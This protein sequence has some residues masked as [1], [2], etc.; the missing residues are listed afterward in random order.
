[1]GDAIVL[2]VFLGVVLVFWAFCCWAFYVGVLRP[3]MD[4]KWPMPR[5]GES[6]QDW[7]RRTGIRP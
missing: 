5:E 7:A 3:W 2:G 4:R 6:L 1:M